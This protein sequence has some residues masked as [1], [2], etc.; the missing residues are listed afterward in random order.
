M[1]MKQTLFR[2][3]ATIAVF[4]MD[5]N[6]LLALADKRMYEDKMARKLRA[7]QPLTMER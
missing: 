4:N 7:G 1:E 5:I 6:N 2:N 3:Q